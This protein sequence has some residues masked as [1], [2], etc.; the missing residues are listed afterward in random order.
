VWH[1]EADRTVDPGNGRAL[2]R[3]WAALH[4]STETAT[5]TVDGARLERWGDDVELWTLPGL[6][7]GY[8]ITPDHPN[9][10]RAARYVLDA[11]VSATDR[12]LR[13][14]GVERAIA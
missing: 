10:G 6:E 2:A 14:W 11:P 12:V 9:D 8:P 7:H 5:R 3:Q 4:A 13:F 1:G